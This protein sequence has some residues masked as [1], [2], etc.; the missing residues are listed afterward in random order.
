MSILKTKAVLWFIIH[1]LIYLVYIPLGC[2]GLFN[3]YVSLDKGNI[4]WWIA[5]AFYILLFYQFYALYIVFYH[6]ENKMNDLFWKTIVAIVLGM[7]VWFFILI[8]PAY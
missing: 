8:H 1:P 6:W 2:L 7:L 4:W 3:Y 5:K